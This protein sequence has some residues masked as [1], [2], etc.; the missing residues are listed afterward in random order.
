[1]STTISRP[2]E[3]RDEPRPW[4]RHY[5]E[6]VPAHLEYPH[7]PVWWLLDQAAAKYPE[8]V[9]CQYYQQVLTYSQLLEQAR[10]AGACLRR[11]GIGPGD[12]IGILLPNMP[13]YLIA[14]YGVWMA[15][16]TV[17]SL[18]PLMVAEEI[19]GLV[20]QTGC[21]VVVSLD[22][23]APLVLEGKARPETV[24]LA[25][26]QDRLSG[27][28]W[29]GYGLH[30]LRT[31]GLRRKPVDTKICSLA[32][33]LAPS[34][35][36]FVAA[37]S[38][39]D[40]PAY[41]LPTGGTTGQPKAVVLT[42]A[43]LMANAW[44]LHHW[45]QQRNG[46]ESLLAVVPF[47]HSFGL[48]SCVTSG[49]A[50]SA[51]LILFHRFRPE[52]VAHL[53]R[54]HRPTCFPAVP[55]MLYALNDEWRKKPSPPG[56][57]G[58]SISGGAP[59]DG[60]IAEEFA[61][62]TGAV[63]VEGYGLSEASPVTH[64]G[65]LDGTARAGTIGLPLPDT[66]A[67][68]VDAPMGRLIVPP[69]AVGELVIRGPQV[70][71][72]YWRRPEETERTIRDGWLYTGDLATCDDDGFFRIVDRKKDLIITSGLNVYPSDVE[73]VLRDYP[74]VVDAAVVGVPDRERG[75]LLKA[76][77]VVDNKNIFSR[78]DFDQFAQRHL[79]RHKRPRLVEVVEGDLPRNYL[80]KLERRKLREGHAT[81]R[82]A[83]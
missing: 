4:L 44:Q 72:G 16:G 45:T 69:G 2:S 9:A 80:G 78:S 61:E 40:E 41:I 43:N 12:R 62:H 59:L 31:T 35:S 56:S 8:R 13:E 14:A 37:Q 23:L 25:T 34:D 19:S 21:R 83:G 24:L 82:R 51:T 32:D 20:Q 33:E 11:R 5:P 1:M 15:G 22:V 52:R 53:I 36:S 64:V 28:Q 48:S 29:L 17:V 39:G 71:R 73:Q 18:S 47:F 79:A 38:S 10:R 26:I 76:I 6:F 55:S 27:W 3:S 67:R 46:Q 7:R 58:Y 68:I 30:R 75:E 74:G 42:H 63:V 66:D 81:A 65:P 70:M 60:A 54:Q 77:L 49:V 57:L 50:A